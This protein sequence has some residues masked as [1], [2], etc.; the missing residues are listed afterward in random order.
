MGRSKNCE[1]CG[2]Q[3]VLLINE[4]RTKYIPINAETTS[5]GDEVFEAATHQKHY[6]IKNKQNLNE[7]KYKE[8]PINSGY[9]R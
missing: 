9:I 3:I 7:V 8:D 6:C 2:V 1:N 4:T 5:A